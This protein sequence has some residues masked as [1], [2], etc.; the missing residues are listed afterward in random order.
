MEDKTPRRVEIKNSYV[1]KGIMLGIVG[2]VLISVYYAMGNFESVKHF[3]SKLNDILMPFYLGVILAYLLCPIYNA[4]VRLTYSL[5]KKK[6]KKPARTL[7]ASRF[8]GSI[9]AIAAIGLAAFGMVMLIVPNLYTSIAELVPKLSMYLDQTTSW[10]EDTLVKNHDISDFLEGRLDNMEDT[11]ITF[12]KEKLLPASESLLSGVYSGAVATIGTLIDIL[13]ALVACI[14]ILNAKETFEAQARKAVIAFSKPG[15]AENVFEFGRLVNTTF[16][17]FINGKIIDSII[18]G[19][20]C[21][22]FMIIFRIP[23]AVLISVVVGITNVI[24]F[25]GPFIGAIPSVL[26]LLVIEPMEALKFII[27]IVILQQFDGNILG[28]K[29]L[30]KTTKLAS[31]W[32]MFAIIV[33]GGFFGVVGMILGVPTFAI[34][35]VYFAKLINSKLGKKDQTTNTMEYSDYSVYGVSKSIFAKEKDENENPVNGKS[36]SSADNRADEPE[37]DGK[38]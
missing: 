34:I 15:K 17:G 3:F 23:Q 28:P 9:A 35:Y 38:Q 33:F 31:F 21:Y 36:D 12:A 13:V 10:I 18:I 32:V 5:L 37:Q 24:P 1:K 7:K 26:L 8:V 2:I 14:Y 27:L 20:I 22:L 6:A 4:V 11:I 16:G 30:G 25:F 29:I 19:I